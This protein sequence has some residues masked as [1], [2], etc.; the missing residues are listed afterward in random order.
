MLVR[1]PLEVLRQPTMWSP[2]C[3]LSSHSVPRNPLLSELQ[4]ICPLTRLRTFHCLPLPVVDLTRCDRLLVF[5]L[6]LPF[7]CLPLTFHCPSLPTT[8]VLSTISIAPYTRVQTQ[9]A[10]Y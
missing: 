4:L 2:C 8:L 1:L 6:P 9:T 5:D 7:H 10:Y 3:P